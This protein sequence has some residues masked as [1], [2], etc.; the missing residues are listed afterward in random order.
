MKTELTE[1][2]F[3]QKVS[4]GLGW[5]H[6]PESERNMI[7]RCYQMQYSVEHTMEMLECLQDTF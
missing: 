2:Q 5:K 3:F 1:V 4:A 6:V 7:K